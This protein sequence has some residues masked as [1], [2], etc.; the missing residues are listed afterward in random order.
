[1]I[2]IILKKFLQCLIAVFLLSIVVFYMARLSPGDPLEAYY[3]N[4]IER[5]N[6][7]QK[8]SAMEK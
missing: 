5:M 8:E 4:A 7:E 1:M 2:K 3:G 6:K